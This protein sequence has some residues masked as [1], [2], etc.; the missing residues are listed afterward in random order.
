MITVRPSTSRVSA[1]TTNS[2]AVT[3]SPTVGSSNKTTGASIN[4][5]RAI[6]TR[7]RCPPESPIPPAE[8]TVSTPSGNRSANSLT[9]AASATRATSSSLA[10]GRP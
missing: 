6:P 5:A 8:M 9:N 7:W 10:S 2:S 4:N 3:S 1:C